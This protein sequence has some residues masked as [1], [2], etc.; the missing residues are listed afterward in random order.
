[1]AGFYGR[2]IKHFSSIAA[3]LHALKRKIGR[4][5]WGEAQQLAFEWLKE[6]L[7]T[8]PVFQLPDFPGNLLSS[9]SLVT[10]PSRQFL[11]RGRG[12]I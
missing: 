7:S 3:P 8:P 5:V 11:M 1:M 9:A 12:M 4:F 6:D 2:F 10:S